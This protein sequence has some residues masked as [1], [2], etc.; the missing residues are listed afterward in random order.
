MNILRRKKVRQI[1]VELCG[2]KDRLHDILSDEKFAYGNI[3]DNLLE[4]RQAE[5][6]EEAIDN[7][8]DCIECCEDAMAEIKDGELKEAAA[9]IDEALITL[10]EVI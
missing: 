2:I 5:E 1:Y 6:S 9:N 7:I 8:D 4:T 10:E 3:P